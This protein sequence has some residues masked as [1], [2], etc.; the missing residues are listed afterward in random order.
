M[1]VGVRNVGSANTDFIRDNYINDCWVSI[2]SQ[3]NKKITIDH[4]MVVMDS[5]ISQ[6]G[7]SLGGDTANTSSVDSNILLGLGITG[8]GPGRWQQRQRDLC[9]ELLRPRERRLCRLPGS[10]LLLLHSTHAAV[11]ASVAR[12]SSEEI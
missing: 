1:T 5:A 12:I 7:I 11:R 2:A 6:T 9:R 10:P 8:G 4:N 3:G